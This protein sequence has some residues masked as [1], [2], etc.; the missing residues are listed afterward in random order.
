MMSNLLNRHRNGRKRAASELRLA[1]ISRRERKLILAAE[2][3]AKVLQLDPMN[4]EARYSYPWALA[5]RAPG[6]RSVI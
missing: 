6:V 2:H 5:E 4:P 1:N 3:Y